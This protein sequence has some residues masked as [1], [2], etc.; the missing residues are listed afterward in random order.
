MN[1]YYYIWKLATGGNSEI[2]YIYVCF[3]LFAN[4]SKFQSTKVN[5][6]KTEK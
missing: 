3:V 4:G 5:I 1:N 2:K 6:Q